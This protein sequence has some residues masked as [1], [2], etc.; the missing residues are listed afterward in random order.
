MLNLKKNN[1]MKFNKI[2]GLTVALIVLTTFSC[3]DMDLNPHDK[4]AE[5][6]FW[7][8][9]SDVDLALAGMYDQLK[10]G[11]PWGSNSFLN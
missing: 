1:N 10:A 3:K 4:L 9:E 11:E 7:Q 2:F 8:S 6:T 5:G